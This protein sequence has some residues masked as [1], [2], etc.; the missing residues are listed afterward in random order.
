MTNTQANSNTANSM[1]HVVRFLKPYL[2]KTFTENG[3]SDNEIYT[4]LAVLE[5]HGF[6]YDQY[7]EYCDHVVF[8]FEHDT[9]EMIIEKI[10]AF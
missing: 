5:S 8:D 2:L 10:H 7:Q 6:K 3:L 9:Y 4:M 1:P